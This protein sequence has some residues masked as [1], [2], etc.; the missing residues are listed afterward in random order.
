MTPVPT[1]PAPQAGGSQTITAAGR[2][3][4]DTFDAQLTGESSVI[5]ILGRTHSRLVQWVDPSRPSIGN[6]LAKSWE[7]PDSLTV[8]FHLDEAA[9]WQDKP[10]LNGRAVSA[11]DVV[12]HFRRSLDIAAGGKAP[13]AQRYDR[14]E[15]ISAVDSPGD[16][17]VRFSLNRPDP[18]LLDTLA[19]EFAL[20]QA[21]EAVEAFSALWSK[22]DSDHVVGSG[23]WSFDWADDG[24]KFA[25]RRGGHRTPLLDSLRVLEPSD[26]AQHFINAA[27]DE[28][29]VRDRRDSE[30]L[31][32]RFGIAT[33]SS[34]DLKDIE[35]ARTANNVFV[36]RRQEREMV[37]SSFAVGSPPWNDP[38]LIATISA[39]LNRGELSEALFGGRAIAAEP[40]PLAL[41]S[42]GIS[43]ERLKFV[44][45]YEKFP[46]QPPET[47]LRDRWAAAGGPGLGTITIDFPSVFDPLYSASSIVV[48]LLN[49][50]LGPQFR[51][52]V[53]TYTTI[54]KRIIDGYY[55]N[56]RAAF[57][58]GWGP[59]FSSPSGERYYAETY[60]PG[61][62][63]QRV[64]GGSGG[65]GT[66]Q[67]ALLGLVNSGFL[68]VVP[69]GRQFAEV[70]RRPGIVAAEPSPF[71]SQHLDY[72]RANI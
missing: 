66:T 49:G 13:V 17:L 2:F 1:A 10:P 4:I 63:G 16:G 59:P 64:S 27:V 19:G 40:I 36:S 46:A 8:L 52:A 57:W 32:S 24:I 37:M 55:G 6:D 35:R 72:Q 45:G 53:E 12:A 5:D 29:L 43:A 41:V 15:T 18:F 69:W 20:I 31:N 21:P 71:W 39:A 56:G 65:T 58:F 38:Q 50:A 11:D 60:A 67:D 51:A 23:P 68:G 28:T 7:T 26:A 61:S 42:G 34:T 14:Y 9:T 25:A 33:G 62:P 47:E 70:Y 44:G 30:L 48:G 22:A 54:S 3:N